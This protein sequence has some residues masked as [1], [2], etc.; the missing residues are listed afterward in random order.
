MTFKF[1]FFF[2]V[3]ASCKLSATFGEISDDWVAGF[4][5]SIITPTNKSV[6]KIRIARLSLAGKKKKSFHM[7]LLSKVSLQI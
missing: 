4:S 5:Q 6:D 2:I 1:S 3:E 7:V